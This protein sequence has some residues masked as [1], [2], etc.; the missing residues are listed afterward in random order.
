MTKGRRPAP[1]KS[2]SLLCS[3]LPPC[4]CPARHRDSG[5]PRESW[6]RGA[7]ALPASPLSGGLRGRTHRSAHRLLLS[8]QGFRGIVSGHQLSLASSGFP[9]SPPYVLINTTANLL[10]GVRQISIS[11]LPLSNH[12][13]L[14]PQQYRL[15][16]CASG[17]D[18]EVTRILPQ[19][20]AGTSGEAAVE[21]A[22]FT[23]NG[24]QT[25]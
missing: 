14:I 11:N 12:A 4:R 8:T 16:L 13:N 17:P 10:G 25:K 3:R 9:L 20:L 5:S 19:Q 7:G 21:R 6:A 23:G 2:A 22:L 18:P 1:Q 15:L 24:G